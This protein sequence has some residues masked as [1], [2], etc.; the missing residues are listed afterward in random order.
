[1]AYIINSEAIIG[2][3]LIELVNQNRFSISFEELLHLEE[4][5][6]E[7]LKGSKYCASFNYTDISDFACDYP[8]FVKVSTLGMLVLQQK[9]EL[10]YSMERYFRVGLPT[11]IAETIHEILARAADMIKNYE[12]AN[13]I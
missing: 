10:T 8:F 4:A 1:M 9:P 6:E 7:N 13:R 2:N 11:V 12:C 5:L 3:F